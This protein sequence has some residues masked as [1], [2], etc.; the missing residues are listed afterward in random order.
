MIFAVIYGAA[1]RGGMEDTIE[2]YVW[3][4]FKEERRYCSRMAVEVPSTMQWLK[5]IPE[6][7]QPSPSP[8]FSAD[9]NLS[10][11][12]VCEVILTKN[13]PTSTLLKSS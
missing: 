10:L 2:V 12:G 1:L 3:L 5:Q 6:T 7:H 4:P 13:T 8:W 9:L 11:L